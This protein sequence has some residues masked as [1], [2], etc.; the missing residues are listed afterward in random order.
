MRELRRFQRLPNLVVLDEAEPTG[1]KATP[2]GDE[3]GKRLLSRIQRLRESG[4]F[5]SVDPDYLHSTHAVPTDDAFNNGTL[6]GLR[7]IGQNGGLTG[8]DIDAVRSWD[9]TTGSTDVIVA[10]IDTGIR[11]THQDL[12]A[13][14]WQNP[15]ESGLLAIDGIDNDNDGYVDNLHGVNAITGAGN[16][17]DDNGHGT[18]CA[19]TIG[20]ASNG[21]GPHV[22]VAWNVRLMALKFMDASGSG[23]TSDAIECIDFAIG[24][25]ARVLSCS[26][27]GSGFE[28]TLRDAILRARNNGILVVAAAGNEAQNSD[29]VAHY[30]SGYEIDNVISVA[31]LDRSDNLAGF[32][33]YGATTVD[34]GAPGVDIYSTYH[35]SDSAYGLL[36]GTSMATPHVAGVAALVIARY[37]GISVF[38]LRQRL[39]GTTVP[40]GSLSGRST[41]GGRLNAYNALTANPD[42]TLELSVSSSSSLVAGQSATVVAQV[43]DLTAISNA[44]VMG[45]ATG[46]PTITFRND[47]VSPDTTANDHLYAATITVPADRD[48][49]TLTLQATAPSKTSQTISASFAIA[50]PPANDNFSAASEL[51]GHAIQAT[52]NN[53]V[54]SKEAG[55]PNHGA[56]N[57]GGRSV[58]WKW[59]APSSGLVTISTRGSTFDTLLGIYTGTSVNSLTLVTN[60]DDETFPSVITSRVQFIATVGTTYRIAVDGYNNGAGAEN[61][62]ITLN[63]S[64]PPANDTFASRS[65]TSGGSWQATGSNLYATKETGEP[66]HANNTGGQSV[67]YT[68]TAPGNGPVVLNTTGSSFDTLLAVYSGSSVNQLTA[69]ASND[70]SAS[71]VTSRLTFT[72]ISGTTYQVAVDGKNTGSSVASG[73][74]ALSLTQNRTPVLATVADQ[75]LD[76]GQTLSLTLSGTDAD[77]PAQS[78]TFYLISGPTGMAV[79][80]AGVL[81]WTPSESQ[82]PSTNAVS[83]A[84]SDGT[85]S[86]SRSFTVTVRELNAAPLLASVADQTIDEGQTL[87][88][89]LSGTDADLP[90][91]TLTFSLISGPTGMAVTSAGVL[92]WTP[93]ESQGPSTNAISVALSDGTT[94]TSRSFTVIVREVNAAP[95]LA[96][97]DNQTLDEGQTL[98]LT[99]SGTDADLPAQTLTFS[100]IS[101]PTGMAVTSAGVL[102]WTPS[103]SQGPSTNAVSVALSD[104]TTS[105]SRSFT[106][107]VNQTSIPIALNGTAIDG[108]IAGGFVWFDANLNGIADTSEPQATTDRQGR[109]ALTVDLKVFDRNQNGRLDL[110]EGRIVVEGGL[111]LGTGIKLRGQLQAPPESSV[112]T[113]LTT[114]VDSV[115]RAT[116]HGSV[117]LAE[118]SVLRSLGLPEVSLT[119][120]DPMASASRGDSSAAIIQAASARVADT[121][122]QLATLLDGLTSAKGFQSKSTAVIDQIATAIANGSALDLG[123][124]TAVRSVLET[125][126]GEIGTTVPEAMASRVAQAVSEQNKLKQDA[127]NASDPI[128]ALRNMT[129]I[130]SVVQSD[131][132]RALS[133][134]ASNPSTLDR[135]TI[136]FTG[137][138]FMEAVK[139]APV[140]DLVTIKNSAGSF[141]FLNSDSRIMESGASPVPLTIVRQ[142]G[143]SGSVGIDIVIDPP[144]GLRTNRLRLLFA[145]GEIQKTIHP[146][147]LVDDDQTPEISQVFNMTLELQTGSPVTARIGSWSTGRLHVMDDDSPGILGFAQRRYTLTEKGQSQSPIVVERQEGA[148]GWITVNV[149]I[150]STNATVGRDYSVGELALDFAPGE[151]VKILPSFILED[152]DPEDAENL[153]LTLQLDPKSPLGALIAADNSIT[154]IVILDDDEAPRLA[155][156]MDSDGGIQLICFGPEG[157]VFDLE[158]SSNLTTWFPAAESRVTAAGFSKGIPI[159]V[160][161]PLR[162]DRFYR[163]RSPQ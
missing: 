52:G 91:Q 57:V 117:A 79:T 89:T 155:C 3:R 108:Y 8:A 28:T 80:S 84:L 63:L 148:A 61:G 29:V 124:P 94:S 11:Y 65:T 14:M 78:L 37:P 99:L 115:A 35:S 100:L 49:L 127:A 90:A 107:I 51:I 128:E 36:N 105:A 116:D 154:E 12:S 134:L 82:G 47:G 17:M 87:S 34:L 122:L 73:S 144:Y 163:I 132:V 121:V 160:R 81:T 26:W 21:S 5:D 42:G 55:E 114:L 147:S 9:V 38:D 39:L 67:W 6:W 32:S 92:T 50:R 152:S 85:T 101:G 135:F 96:T 44:T 146:S 13:Q 68:W 58:W 140:G 16:P 4:L 25:G 74:I 141:N 120:F 109:F 66:N 33:N 60:N 1:L 138:T 76:E 156:R 53:Q 30:P 83:V 129:R 158:S 56:N 93:S 102:T 27:G 10:V 149:L 20:A 31:A 118:S 103:E 69:V 130:Q 97:I 88:L 2:G 104:G 153:T 123:D 131:V 137:D 95:V 126:A 162:T 161:E 19:G 142:D 40:V 136:Q 72:A 106:I 64:A 46:L 133:E 24:K 22:G 48:L 143:S 139:K 77:L 7:N 145:D 54:A 75:T 71:G 86:A 15:G 110:A 151:L 18:H 112:V 159:P 62:S 45:T 98:S 157:A 150:R 43:T 119:Q 111:D 113:P 59:T 41:A 23:F 70:D 125:A